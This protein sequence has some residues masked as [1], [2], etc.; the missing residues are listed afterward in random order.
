MSNKTFTLSD[1]LYA[2]LTSVSLREPSILRRLRDETASH[3]KRSMQIAPEQGQL[4]QLL[5]RAM[6]VR[7]AI[8]IGVFTGYSALSVALALPPDG[9]LVACDVNE[10]YVSVARRY[11]KEA[12]VDSR[13]DLRMGPA[14]DTLDALIGN[15]ERGRFDLVFIDADKGN[16]WHYFERSLELLRPGGLIII[17]NVLWSGK[18][19]DPAS[20]D[21]DA[22]QIRAFNL[23][24]KDDARVIISML[25]IADGLTLAMKL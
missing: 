3:P 5:V 13:I 18:V 12:G 24:L 23:R 22:Q 1:E 17:D 11:W 21:Q 14:L 6:G 16:Y 19:A 8:E 10:E 20:P 25:P 7:R 9:I 2:Y 4:M 15:G